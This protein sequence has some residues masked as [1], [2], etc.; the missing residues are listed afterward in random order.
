M[1]GQPAFSET[2]DPNHRACAAQAL[3]SQVIDGPRSPGDSNGLIERVREVSRRFYNHD[4]TI[5][6]GNAAITSGLYSLETR[7]MPKCKRRC[8]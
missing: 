3:G 4:E 5:L 8:S 7:T 2:R 6:P 1:K